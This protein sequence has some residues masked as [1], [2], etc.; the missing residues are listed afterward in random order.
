[1]SVND[2]HRQLAAEQISADEHR[3]FVGGLWDELGHW[4]FD[5]LRGPGQLTPEMTLLDLGCGCLRG[6]VHFI[7]YL[8]P[9]HY[10]GIDVNTSLIKAALEVELPRAGL[11]S[12][13]P[14]DHLLVTGDF[15][16]T[17]FNTHFDR[18]LAVSLWTHLPLNHILL[19]LHQ[20]ARVLRPA[21]RFYT[22]VFETDT[23][24]S[25]FLPAQHPLGIV[26]YCHQDPYHL[27]PRHIA[28]LLDLHELPFSAKRLG[29]LG[30]PRGQ[31][32]WEFTRQ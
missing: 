2:Y 7:P 8:Q 29:T 10:Y 24:Q 1:M 6:G 16:A 3:Q 14:A 15:D 18:V 26:S 31:V 19:S 32:V 27:H 11:Q 4:Q 28:Q 25:W 30:H 17:P 13:L 21:G 23:V 22:T 12:R 20:M 9:G 5:L